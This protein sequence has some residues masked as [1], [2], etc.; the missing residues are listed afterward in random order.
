MQTSNRKNLFIAF[1]GGYLHSLGLKADGSIVA[2]G[3]NR[4]EQT[5]VPA[6]NSH[7]TFISSNSSGVNGTFRFA[8]R[9]RAIRSPNLLGACAQIRCLSTKSLGAF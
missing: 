1:A 2:W 9:G 4:Y 5:T 8:G 6:P 3:D 7:S